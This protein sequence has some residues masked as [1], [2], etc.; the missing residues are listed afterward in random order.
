MKRK[1]ITKKL[2]EFTAEPGKAIK[3]G[4]SYGKKFLVNVANENLVTEVPES[5]V[6]SEETEYINY[7]E[8]VNALIRERYSVSQEFAIL[9][10]RD[11]KPEEYKQYNDYCEECKAKVKAKI[12]KV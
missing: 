11:T 7:D 1:E 2:I 3:Y 8:E 10:Q 9:R 12:A 6:P 4:D 5:E